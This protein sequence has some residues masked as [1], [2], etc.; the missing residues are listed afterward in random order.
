MIELRA[1]D[2]AQDQLRLRWP[3]PKQIAQ[4]LARFTTGDPIELARYTLVLHSDDLPPE[5][6]ESQE[7]TR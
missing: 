7:T 3:E 6:G 5:I 1:A 2:T 4:K